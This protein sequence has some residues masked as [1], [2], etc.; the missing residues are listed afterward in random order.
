[1]YKSLKLMLSKILN[2]KT[3][4][5]IDPGWLSLQLSM[6]TYPCLHSLLVSLELYCVLRRSIRWTR[7]CIYIYFIGG[8]LFIGIVDN[9]GLYCGGER[10]L[11]FLQEEGNETP[12]TT[13]VGK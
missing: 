3:V 5:S 2:Y 12:F 9:F 8:I 10:D 11:L 1:M 7:A 4:C 6:S 13:F